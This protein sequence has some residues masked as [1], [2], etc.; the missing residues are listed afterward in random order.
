MSR[1]ENIIIKFLLFL[2]LLSGAF[3]RLITGEVDIDFMQFNAI[4]TNGTTENLIVIHHRL[5]ALLNAVFVGA[6]LSLAGYLMQVV[7]K[8]ALA[9]PYILGVASGA[10]LFV[11]VFL[12]TGIS[13]ILATVGV[14]FM[15]I[16]GAMAVAL[17][18]LLL[19]T[20]IRQTTTIL[21]VG[22]LISSVATAVISLLQYFSSDEKL[23]KFIVWTMGN[24]EASSLNESLLIA[25]I[26]VLVF[27]IIRARQKSINLLMLPDNKAFS[28]GLNVKHTQIISLLM[29]SVVTGVSV[30]FCGPIGFVGIV[31]PH[32]SAMLVKTRL[33][34]FNLF[35][36]FLTGANLVLYADLLAHLPQGTLLPVNAI[37]A[38]FGIPVIFYIVLRKKSVIL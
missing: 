33:V 9:G 7:F 38:I 29:A 21:I 18:L 36:L 8:N 17:L 6:G 25:T 2:L 5:P 19:L 20:K 4:F 35:M 31:V 14:S 24:T 1:R 22:V 16:V 15:A 37:L 13:C 28:L 34:Q 3:L 11:A 12:L 10:G 26:T 23:K 30:A 27:L 32:L